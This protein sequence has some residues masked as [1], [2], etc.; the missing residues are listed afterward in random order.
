MSFEKG[1]CEG[2][3]NLVR[4]FSNRASIH[5]AAGAGMRKEKASFQISPEAL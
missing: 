2:T 4:H 1:K 5:D 3:E